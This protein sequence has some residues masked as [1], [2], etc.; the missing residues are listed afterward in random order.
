VFLLAL[1]ALC[2]LTVPLLGGRLGRLS[3]IEFRRPGLAIAAVVLQT[4]TLAVLPGA[5]RDLLAALHLLSYALLL[6]FLL[7]N[8]TLPGLWLV[9]LGG[10]LNALAIAV[11]G[12]VMPARPEALA[13][14]GISQSGGTFVNSGAVADPALWFLGDVFAVPEGWPLANVFSI[15]DVLLIVGAFVLVHRICGSAARRITCAA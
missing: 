6:G 7:A 1:L 3:D 8:L 2:L 5:D 4:L 13:A 15:G 14:A 11:N 9:G 12:G 10:G